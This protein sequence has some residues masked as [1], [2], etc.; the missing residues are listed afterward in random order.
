M[1]EVHWIVLLAAAGGIFLFG[2]WRGIR[3]FEKAFEHQK[4]TNQGPGAV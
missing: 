1:I 4:K 3:D 2:R